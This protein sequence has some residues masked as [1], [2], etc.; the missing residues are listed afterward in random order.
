MVLLARLALALFLSW[1]L[2]FLFYVV[3]F[4]VMQYLSRITD[5]NSAMFGVLAIG[6]GAG[7][8]SFL[9]WL[10]RDLRLRYLMLVLFLTMAATLLGAWGGLHN[11]KDVFQ[12]SGLLGNP[13]LKGIT[14]GAILGGNIFNLAVWLV[15]IIRNPRI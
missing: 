11:S 15:K 10:N 12:L 9:G 5:I 1:V 7:I 3:T 2:G 4:P 8:G 13:A 6:T 14:V